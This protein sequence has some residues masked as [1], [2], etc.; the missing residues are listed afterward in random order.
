MK[1]E[2]KHE[3]VSKK[4]IYRSMGILPMS[5]RAILALS[6]A[7]CWHGQ[8]ARDTHGRDAHA[9]GQTASQTYS[10]LIVL[11][12]LFAP[13]PASSP[14]PAAPKPLPETAVLDRVDGRILR[15]DANDTWL[16]ELSLEV[17]TPDYRLP[18]GTRFEL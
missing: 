4:P 16:F 7:G 9:T 18:A 13:G 3:R 10:F 2:C 1:A 11:I 6:C 12:L 5:R 17:K 15:I 14:Q 8:D